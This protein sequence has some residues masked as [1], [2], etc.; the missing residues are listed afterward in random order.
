ML[1]ERYAA[2]KKEMLARGFSEERIEYLV[3]LSDA[4]LEE[5]FGVKM[6]S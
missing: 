6:E 5:N 4:E 1:E 3:Q 2:A